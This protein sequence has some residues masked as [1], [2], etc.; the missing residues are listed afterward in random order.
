MNLKLLALLSSVLL[1]SGLPA[2]TQQPVIVPAQNVP[3]A[4]AAP[5]PGP[6]M[7]G[8][9]G[10]MQTLQQMKATNADL[11]RKQQATLQQLD[12]LEKAIEQVK[13]YSRRS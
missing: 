4:V 3:P 13:I 8:A 1:A 7:S 6:A 9:E 2:Q 12:E 10:V 11:L 5:Q